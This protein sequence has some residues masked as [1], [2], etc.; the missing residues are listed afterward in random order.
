MEFLRT[1]SRFLFFTGKGGVG[2][3]SI[4]CAT[5]VTL[6]GRG[7]RVLLVS[8]DPASNLDQV[9]ETRL[10]GTPT[11]IPGAPG[12]SALN[13]DPE[14]T[15]QAYR[16][17]ALAPLLGIASESE[18]ADAREQLSGACTVE[19]AAFDRFT[20]LLTDPLIATDYDHVIF[21][22]APTGHTLRLLALPAAWSGYI[23]AN[24]RGAACL[25]PTAALD[26]HHA[27]YSA[28]VEALSDPAR[29]T[30]VLVAR[31]ERGALN[32]AARTSGDLRDMGLA[33]QHLVING[34]FHATD[35]TDAVAL[36]WERR[37]ETALA[38]RPAALAALP[39][40][41]VPLRPFNVV[42]LDAVRSLLR[43]DQATPL[44]APIS[45]QHEP[46]PPLG[47][48]IDDL[49]SAG[50]GLVM[51]MGKG[52][53]GKTTVAAAIAVE[54]AAR[55][56]T[57]Q[58]TT[59]DP[60]AHIAST[61][62]GELPALT[63]GRIDPAAERAAYISR[64]MATK[65]SNL[66][67][68]ARGLLLEDL[69]SPCT[70]EVAV[71]HAFSRFIS[72]ARTGFVVLDT[73]PTGH[74]LLLLDTTGAYHT[75]IIRALEGQRGLAGT[76]TP[77]MR[78]RDPAYTKTMIVTL[79]ETTPVSEAEELQADLRRAG[80]EPYAWV[81]NASLSASGVRDPLLRSRADAELPQIERVRNDLAHRA[82]LIP[83]QPEE[84]VGIE[85]LRHLA[86]QP[87]PA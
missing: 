68:Q 18:I 16:D 83:W 31:P 25:G 81:V 8:T 47:T 75:E 4:A 36:A 70:E 6:A 82:V 33:N 14:A 77:L 64:V 72:K 38:R 1:P 67:E 61:V 7:L 78:L 23:D 59:T 35:R 45:T 84:P 21:D 66:D 34:R 44:P 39:H 50:H 2:K 37:A 40:S 60:A 11:P 85:R 3:T 32:E 41:E 46:L 19:I 12:L 54:L 30:L 43:D 5:A 58:L 71:F 17:R 62:E 80:I 10:G 27:Q 69:Q 52:G 63:V 13:I 56:H 9:L 48:L 79:P 24:R 42:G 28:A 20:A 22:T 86:E 87:V 76:T 55:G 74:T 57:V 49:E 15:A 51:V 26:S 53:V 73:A 29:T 65:G